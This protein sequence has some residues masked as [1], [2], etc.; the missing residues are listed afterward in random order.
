MTH[1]L[2]MMTFQTTPAP[3]TTATKS[4]ASQSAN[5]PKIRSTSTNSKLSLARYILAVL[6][7]ATNCKAQSI[8]TR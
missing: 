8:A 3:P 7:P 2:K 5:H 4:P 1:K 6:L